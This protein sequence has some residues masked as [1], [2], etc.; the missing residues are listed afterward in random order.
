MNKEGFPKDRQHHNRRAG[1]KEVHFLKK[2][3]G[4]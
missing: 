2:S 3:T 4:G 1:G